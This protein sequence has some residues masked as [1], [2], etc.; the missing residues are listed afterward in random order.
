ML[1]QD[2]IRDKLPPSN[3]CQALLNSRSLTILLSKRNHTALIFRYEETT[4]Y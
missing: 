2:R 3:I 1:F 4:A